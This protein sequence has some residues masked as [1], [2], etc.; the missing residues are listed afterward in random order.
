MYVLALR[1]T[2]II[3]RKLLTDNRASLVAQMV[4]NLP[5]MQETPVPSLGRED[6]LEKEM[7]TY[8]SILAWGISWM[9][10]PGH[11][12]ETARAHTHTHVFKQYL[13]AVAD[14]YIYQHQPHHNFYTSLNKSRLLVCF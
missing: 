11:N 12:S 8:S 14:R 10:E 13:E 7:A 5:A 4:K 6:T 9:E 2:V 3:G 1:W